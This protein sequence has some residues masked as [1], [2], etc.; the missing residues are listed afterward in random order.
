GAGAVQPPSTS[1]Y[2]PVIGTT[3]PSVTSA[4]TSEVI[5]RKKLEA[6][7]FDGSDDED[8]SARRSAQSSDSEIERRR[9]KEKKDKERDRDLDREKI[10]VKE[11]DA[12]KP[13]VDVMK[14][15]IK[16]KV[17]VVEPVSSKKP[18]V[19]ESKRFKEE[20]ASIATP[21]KSKSNG[22]K[23]KESKDREKDQDR[24]KKTQGST[25]KGG[26]RE[27]KS[28]MSDDSGSSV[29]PVN[30]SF[31]PDRRGSVSG[32]DFKIPAASTTASTSVSKSSSSSSKSKEREKEKENGSSTVRKTEGS[33][34]G[35]RKASESSGTVRPREPRTRTITDED[36]IESI[37]RSVP[38]PESDKDDGDYR[39]RGA[40]GVRRK[41][42]SGP[43]TSGSARKDRERDDDDEKDKKKERR[44]SQDSQDVK[45]NVASVKK[46]EP[47]APP[48]TDENEDRGR[49]GSSPSES[50]NFGSGK[51]KAPAE[52]WTR[53]QIEEF[54]KLAAASAKKE[55]PSGGADRKRKRDVEEGDSDDDDDSSEEE[56]SEDNRV[57]KKKRG[58]PAA[59]DKERE[60]EKERKNGHSGRPPKR[61]NDDKDKRRK[62]KAKEK[63]KDKSRAM[64]IE[65]L[66][67]SDP[68]DS[69]DD[70]DGGSSSSSESEVEQQPVRKRP[71]RPPG[72]KPKAVALAVTNKSQDSS[73][74]HAHGTSGRN[75]SPQAKPPRPP[76]QEEGVL[77][78]GRKRAIPYS[79]IN[80]PDRSGRTPLF[81]YAA[82]GD[83]E[84]VSALIKGGADV[85]VRDHAGWTPLH[86]ACLEGQRHVC[87]ILITYGA[88]VNAASGHE[89]DTPLHDAV[90]N[91]H[92]DVVEVLLSHGALMTAVNRRSETPLDLAEEEPML[93]L[94]ERWRQM[95]AEVVEAD[96]EGLTML[97][98]AATGGDVKAVRRCLKY[99]AEVD[100]ADNAGW[101]P[102]HE[103]AAGGHSAIVEELCRYGADVNVKSIGKKEERDR[104]SIGV[105]PLMD[106]AAYCD[107]ETVKILLQF[108]ADVGIVDGD[109]KS[110]VDYIP[111]SFPK[112]ADE[113][114]V[115]ERRNAAAEVREL[116]LRPKESW[117]PYR[118]PDFVKAI[119]GSSGMMANIRDEASNILA[120]KEAHRMGLAS[121]HGR[122]NSI[123]SDTSMS[124]N[125]NSFSTG[126]KGSLT[127]SAA[128][129]AAVGLGGANP[130]SWGGLD[131]RER[132]GPFASSRE[133]RKFNALLRTI[134][135][136]DSPTS[137]APNTP[138]IEKPKE[139]RGRKRKDKEGTTSDEGKGGEGSGK[140]RGAPKKVRVKK[141]E[142]DGEDES[143]NGADE[144]EK[145]RGKKEK[146]DRRRREYRDRQRNNIAESESEEDEAEDRKKTH[147]SSKRP[148]GD[149]G[150]D[151]GGDKRRK[152]EE[153][154]SPAREKKGRD[155]APPRKR[156]EAQDRDSS[157]AFKDSSTRSSPDRDKERERGLRPDR[158]ADSLPRRKSESSLA[159]PDSVKT[160]PSESDRLAA[161]IFSEDE[162]LKKKVADIKAQ[163]GKERKREVD[164]GDID[165]NDSKKANLK[166]TTNTGEQG[167][168]AKSTS[169]PAL[170]TGQSGKSTPRTSISPIRQTSLNDVNVKTKAQTATSSTTAAPPSVLTPAP[171]P[172]IKKKPKRKNL[173]GISGYQKAGDE[174]ATG[175]S[176]TPESSVISMEITGSGENLAASTTTENP[177]TKEDKMDVDEVKDAQLGQDVNAI[178]GDIISSPQK[179]EEEPE[180]AVELTEEE[181][182]RSFS[183]ISTIADTGKGGAENAAATTATASTVKSAVEEDAE[184]ES[185]KDYVHKLKRM[186]GGPPKL[187]GKHGK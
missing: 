16:K 81:K 176:T 127:V 134:Q 54:E 175:T 60:K 82:R 126:G 43:S 124:T 78:S 2:V 116:L 158:E 35:D 103:A 155:E 37:L 26:E 65:H 153:G 151:D 68:D 159:K 106:G 183:G 101:T 64:K 184:A 110:A 96:T 70:G 167:F 30:S 47:P 95:M 185:R 38:L 34:S 113:R 33:A 115:E 8:T 98:K 9:G 21:A 120:R 22:E 83:T 51:K 62:E 73:P 100:F 58:R 88:D 89:G 122:K 40:K 166:S 137:Q 164:N 121:K 19:V 13:N 161:L 162:D 139:T 92:F 56:S 149:T 66:F 148:A 123:S 85:N 71:G 130:F 15:R 141:E 91:G 87:E 135:S 42:G 131:P 5:S 18:D 1:G 152:L 52:E 46:K 172:V 140:G 29:K 180:K 129:A 165:S 157:N 97:H 67:D 79:A 142:D 69:S 11:H 72:R 144:R 17:D 50:P 104:H 186:G 168:V 3:A 125:Q 74:G 31:G 41:S 169:K 160:E 108:G 117:E 102:L 187:F 133:E 36:D 7:L 61:T 77:I 20:A 147:G 59:K 178:T 90:T 114:E 138:G 45:G 57:V 154:A 44:D 182:E 25:D 132:D 76:R 28:R 181:K 49:Q 118:R 55:K 94:L 143:D 24:E 107:R 105:T 32:G 23:D 53:R 119:P 150:K 112:A 174:P 163:E 109:G 177:L 170:S 156:T 179:Q 80:T 136:I 93:G 4:S 145:G 12:E 146:I 10:K 39:D 99:G 111:D 86:E 171:A 6:V 14:K 128:T 63:D 27:K 75:R 84:T 48:L 173:F